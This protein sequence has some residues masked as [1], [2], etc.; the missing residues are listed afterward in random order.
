MLQG[1]S[2]FTPPATVAA[3]LEERGKTGGVVRARFGN[4]AAGLI[5]VQKP[6]SPMRR[7]AKATRRSRSC[8]PL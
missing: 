5:Q 6:E 8:I 1:A 4:I 2:T 7:P 3:Y